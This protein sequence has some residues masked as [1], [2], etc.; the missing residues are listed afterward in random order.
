MRFCFLLIACFV[1]FSCGGRVNPEASSNKKTDCSCE[2]EADSDLTF[3]DFSMDILYLLQ[4][5]NSPLTMTAKTKQRVKFL[6]SIKG[7]H[8]TAF[9][10]GPAGIQQV[11]IIADGSVNIGQLP[12]TTYSNITSK[13][14]HLPQHPPDTRLADQQDAYGAIG[15]GSQ[16]KFSVALMAYQALDWLS[17][18]KCPASIS[19]H[20]DSS[21]LARDAHVLLDFSNGNKIRLNR[22]RGQVT[23]FRCNIVWVGK[24]GN[25]KISSSYSDAG[26]HTYSECGVRMPEHDHTGTI[27]HKQD[28]D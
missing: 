11:T 10:T 7:Q 14:E 5:W 18:P 12:I 3:S 22:N 6:Q 26:Y 28:G 21:F 8:L 9:Y 1:S 13:D 23:C 24:D 4:R 2:E 16:A 20:K 15:I 19:Y 17:N 25:L 27:P